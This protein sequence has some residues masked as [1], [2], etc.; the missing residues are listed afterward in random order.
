MSV[1]GL[2]LDAAA[3]AEETTMAE[4][5]DAFAMLLSLGTVLFLQY[6]RVWSKPLGLFINLLGFMRQPNHIVASR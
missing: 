1:S 2:D 6:R 5:D 4:V 3:A